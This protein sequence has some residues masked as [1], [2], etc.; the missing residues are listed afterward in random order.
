MALYS[1]RAA[2]NVCGHHSR[3]LAYSFVSLVIGFI[4]SLPYRLVLPQ[5]F[6]PSKDFISTETTIE[7][8]Y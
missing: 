6:R 1:L 4:R 5:Q 2:N 3:G 7:N 8:W